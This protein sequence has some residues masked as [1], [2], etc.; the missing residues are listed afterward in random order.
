MFFDFGE[1]KCPVCGASGKDSEIAGLSECPKCGA[2][3]NE[4]GVAYT[5]VAK[6]D[7]HWS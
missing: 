1:G 7:L 2:Q 4:F 3:F 5:N 6:I